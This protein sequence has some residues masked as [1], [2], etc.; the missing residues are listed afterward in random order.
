M[1]V[2]SGV[3]KNALPDI[4]MLPLLLT[5]VMSTF[6]LPGSSASKSRMT[7]PFSMRISVILT[8]FSLLYCTCT[9]FKLPDS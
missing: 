2:R 9:S 6:V 1:M 7:S 5:K 3:T 8:T 4:G